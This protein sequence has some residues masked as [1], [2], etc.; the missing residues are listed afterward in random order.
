MPRNGPKAT[1]LFTTRSSSEAELHPLQRA[2]GLLESNAV[3]DEV[4]LICANFKLLQ[5]DQQQPASASGSKTAATRS[6]KRA[7]AL[8][9]LLEREYGEGSEFERQC[10]ERSADRDPQHLRVV[11]LRAKVDPEKG[12]LLIMMAVQGINSGDHRSKKLVNAA[13]CA[14]SDVSESAVCARWAQRPLTS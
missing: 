1:M 10:M 13:G 4:A 7:M 6:Y 2:L 5:L 3:A 14:V 9:T 12:E 8:Q 11:R